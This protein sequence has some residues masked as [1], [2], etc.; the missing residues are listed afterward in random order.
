LKACQRQQAVE[1]ARLEKLVHGLVPELEK[2][3]GKNDPA[4]LLT[5]ILQASE[6]TIGGF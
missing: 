6:D 3:N 1:Y 2:T 4:N 5:R